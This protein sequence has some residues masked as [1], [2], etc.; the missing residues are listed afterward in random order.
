M[1]SACSAR[2]LVLVL[3]STTY[4][5][6]AV[7]R[8]IIHKYKCLIW[9]WYNERWEPCVLCRCTLAWHLYCTF[10]FINIFII[11]HIFMSDHNRINII[12]K[13][14]IKFMGPTRVQSYLTFRY[15]FYYTVPINKYYTQLMLFGIA[16]RI[17]FSHNSR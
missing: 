7:V 16:N 2:R 11:I 10:L 17:F 13:M 15:F 6:T 12:S 1:L 4:N 9:I 8:C 3:S 5:R 14:H